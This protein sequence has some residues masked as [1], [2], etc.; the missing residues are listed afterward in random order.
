MLVAH[1]GHD[2][3]TCLTA[4]SALDSNLQVILAFYQT[5]PIKIGRDTPSNWDATRQNFEARDF[6]NY[7]H[8]IFS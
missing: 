5:K 8:L 7:K 2:A 4:P 6:R 1:W 3:N